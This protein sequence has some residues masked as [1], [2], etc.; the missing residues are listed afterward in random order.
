MLS[1]EKARVMSQPLWT[2]LDLD[3]QLCRDDHVGALDVAV[4]DDERQ[5]MQIVVPCG[6]MR[7]KN[8][9][10]RFASNATTTI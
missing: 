1:D 2:R 10:S 5:K 9:Y 7:F 6:R 8:Q 4:D 3:S